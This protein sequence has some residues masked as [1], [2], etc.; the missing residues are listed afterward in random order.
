MRDAPATTT[1][2]AAA[3]APRDGLGQFLG[4]AA[5]GQSGR[6]VLADGGLAQMQVVRS[7]AAASGRECREVLVGAGRSSLYCRSEQGWTAT[8]PLLLGSGAA[9]P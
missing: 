8:R 4:G 3:A 1:P 9:R 2:P 7:Y 5:Q 6:V